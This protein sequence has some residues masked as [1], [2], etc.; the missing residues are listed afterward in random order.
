VYLDLP[1]EVA[2]ARLTGR[3]EGRSDD[4]DPSI[5]DRRLAVYHESTQ[6]LLD[7]YRRR[8]LLV[9]VDASRPVEDVSRAI[10]DALE[11]RLA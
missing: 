8:G 11:R 7:F 2:K 9:T 4:R 5:V 3:A 6:P 1:D 10:I